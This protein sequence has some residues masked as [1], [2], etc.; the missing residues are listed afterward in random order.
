MPQRGKKV[1]LLA[2]LLALGVM[3]WAAFSAREWVVESYRLYQ[4]R[5]GDDD[6]RDRALRDLWRAK[7]HRLS[8]LLVSMLETQSADGLGLEARRDLSEWLRKCVR[9]NAKSRESRLSFS[10]PALLRLLVDPEPHVR[11]TAMCALSRTRFHAHELEVWPHLS[12]AARDRSDPE[13]RRYAVH[14]MGFLESSLEKALPYLRTIADDPQEHP[15]VSYEARE[16]LRSL[17]ILD[18]RPRSSGR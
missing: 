8:P 7:S 1:T 14:A 16:T 18:R 13:M 12:R 5:H 6:V 4:V 15:F 9:C 3:G 11:A 2:A 17:G 10:V